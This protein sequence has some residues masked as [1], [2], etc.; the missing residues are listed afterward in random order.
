MVV[1]GVIHAGI[2][3]DSYG[4]VLVA[5]VVQ[6]IVVVALVFIILVFLDLVW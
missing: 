6:I 4:T 5:L 3:I 1:D 2:G